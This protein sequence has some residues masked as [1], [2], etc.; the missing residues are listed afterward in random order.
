M[1][2]NGAKQISE[3]S[4]GCKGRF[5]PLA[6]TYSGET[7]DFQQKAKNTPSFAQTSVLHDGLRVSTICF[8]SPT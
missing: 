8:H 4:R 2:K 5:A 1:W 3:H 6:Y 7:N